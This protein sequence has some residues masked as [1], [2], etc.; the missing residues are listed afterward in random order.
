MANQ[1]AGKRVRSLN[2][3]LAVPIGLSVVSQY[4]LYRVLFNGHYATQFATSRGKHS[5]GDTCMS[6]DISYST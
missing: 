1:E 2:I 6:D 3:N 4:Q 5:L